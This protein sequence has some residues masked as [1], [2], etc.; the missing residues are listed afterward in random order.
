MHLRADFEHRATIELPL[1]VKNASDRG[2]W[3][4]RRAA[5]TW[6]GTFCAV[7]Y[8]CYDTQGII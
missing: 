4:Y 5:L 7:H 1:V 6:R 2:H 8:C 3:Q